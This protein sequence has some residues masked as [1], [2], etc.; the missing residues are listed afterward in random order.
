VKGPAVADGAA[1]DQVIFFG[2]PVGLQ[3][4]SQMPLVQPTELDS[5][6]LQGLENELLFQ[7]YAR[8]KDT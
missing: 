5:A 4:E 2:Q 1:P 6:I 7:A 8:T 3:L